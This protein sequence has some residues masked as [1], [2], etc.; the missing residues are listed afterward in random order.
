MARLGTAG[1][2]VAAALMPSES[3]GAFWDG[4]ERIVLPESF[5]VGS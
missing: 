1:L 5:F 2:G 3:R 4:E